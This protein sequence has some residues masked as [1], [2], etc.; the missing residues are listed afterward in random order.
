MKNT[1]DFLKVGLKPTPAMVET[2][3]KFDYMPL[4]SEKELKMF[5][6]QILRAILVLRSGQYPMP[7]ISDE[8]V[9]QQILVLQERS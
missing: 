4:F 6:P 5:A 9:I 3:D 2:V 8:K 7:H 1:R